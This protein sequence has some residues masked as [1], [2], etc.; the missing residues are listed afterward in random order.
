VKNNY[1]KKGLG[2]TQVVGTV[3]KSQYYPK[4]KIHKILLKKELPLH[5][6]LY[7]SSNVFQER[8]IE[9]EF[10]KAI[11]SNCLAVRQ[12]LSFSILSTDLNPLFKKLII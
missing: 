7:F 1:S 11:L 6:H 9:M 2:M 12:W 5:L 4:K 8:A 3:F 10:L